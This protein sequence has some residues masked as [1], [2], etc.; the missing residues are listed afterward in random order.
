M[1]L[2]S[3]LGVVNAPV[4]IINPLLFVQFWNTYCFTPPV[5]LTLVVADIVC[6]ELMFQLVNCKLCKSL[7][8][9]GTASIDK[10]VPW[11]SP[12]IVW[13]VA[14]EIMGHTSIVATGEVTVA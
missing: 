13:L 3:A 5:T 9:Y 2:A 1:T 12:V 14:N 7:Y 11:A 4:A 10:T 6:V 8:A